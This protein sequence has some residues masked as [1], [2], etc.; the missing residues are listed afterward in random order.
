[1]DQWTF[2]HLETDAGQWM[3]MLVIGGHLIGD[4]MRVLKWWQFK[5]TTRLPQRELSSSL[6]NYRWTVGRNEI[7]W[8]STVEDNGNDEE[9]LSGCREEFQKSIQLSRFELIEYNDG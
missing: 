4:R 1:M 5:S 9:R 2:S 7:Q 8:W 6:I 3:P